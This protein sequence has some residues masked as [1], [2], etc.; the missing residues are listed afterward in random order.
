MRHLQQGFLLIEILLSFLMITLFIGICMRYQVS[1]R[2]WQ[3][4]ALTTMEV[5]NRLDL[6]LDEYKKGAQDRVAFT[7]GR[8]VSINKKVVPVSLPQVRGAPPNFN[9]AIARSM[10]AMTLCAS[11]SG[12]SGF[13][14]CCMPLIF[15]EDH[16][17]D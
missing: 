12:Q 1:I 16:D 15:R 5:V 3:I 6:I 4:Q 10:K 14:Q 2:G 11:W 9:F 13:Q 8:N 7:V 17:E